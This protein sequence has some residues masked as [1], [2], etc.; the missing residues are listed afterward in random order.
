MFLV[1]NL[2]PAAC[3]SKSSYELSGL[4]GFTGRYVLRAAKPR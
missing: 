4:A 2:V 1:L 3:I